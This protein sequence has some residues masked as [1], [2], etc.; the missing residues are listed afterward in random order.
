MT[1]SETSTDSDVAAFDRGDI[2]YDRLTPSDVKIVRDGGPKSALSVRLD[3]ADINR[4]RLRA[5]MEGVGLTQLV[6]RWILERLD[7]P[8]PGEAIVDLMKA[9][10]AGLKAAQVIKRTAPTLRPPQ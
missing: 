10:E 4:L 1:T 8:P 2:D 5:E 9:L 6:R 7:E 3:G